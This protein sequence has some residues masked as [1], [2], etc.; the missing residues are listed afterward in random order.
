[1]SFATVYLYSQSPRVSWISDLGKYVGLEIESVS[2]AETANFAEI[3]PL[4]KVPAL[5]TA[6]GFKL[7]ESIA[8]YLYIVAKS[9]KPEFAGVT[10]EEK[11]NNLR[12]LS[13]FNSDVINAAMGM[14]MGKTDEAK[15]ESKE[16]TL[17]ILKYLDEYLKNYPTKFLSSNE[18]LVGD[19]FVNKLLQMI[20]FV[21]E[22]ENIAAYMDAVKEHPIISGN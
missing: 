13:F 2:A 20:P 19:I 5:V 17:V 11:A 10:E 7:T 1:M 16:K 6:D 9:S 18:I 15:E 8:I 21:S 22:F 14:F 4:K 3:F 12:W